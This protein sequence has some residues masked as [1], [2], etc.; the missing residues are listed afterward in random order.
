ME[1]QVP[2]PEQGHEGGNKDMVRS[3]ELSGAPNGFFGNFEIRVI[4]QGNQ[5]V[6]EPWLG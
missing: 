4:E 5:Q 2:M 6:P 1:L 3:A